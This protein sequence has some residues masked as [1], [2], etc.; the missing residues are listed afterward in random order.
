MHTVVIPLSLSL[1]ASSL[2]VPTDRWQPRTSLPRAR[3]PAMSATALSELKVYELKAVCRAKGLKVSGRK[4]ELVERIIAAGSGVPSSPPAKK[5]RGRGKRATAAPTPTPPPAATFDAD[6]LSGA[7][8]DHNMWC[9]G[10][11]P[12]MCTA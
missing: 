9:T 10:P 12:P 5:G 3:S 6:A 1:L 2:W 4:A 11:R 8:C 7:T